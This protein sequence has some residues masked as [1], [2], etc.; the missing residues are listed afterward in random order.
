MTEAELVQI[1]RRYVDTLFPKTCASCGRRYE[2]VRDYIRG[3]SSMER[4]V[5]DLG[6]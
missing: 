5:R 1:L 2:T 4:P 3:R 6:R